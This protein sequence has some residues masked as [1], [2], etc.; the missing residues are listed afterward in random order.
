MQKWVM[1]WHYA[2]IDYNYEVGVFENIT[3]RAVIR[4]NLSGDK[5]KVCFQN[6]YSDAPMY[7]EHVK[8]RTRNRR[9]GMKSEEIEVTYKGNSQIVL[10]P[11]T[12]DFSDEIAHE[13]T[14]EDDFI[15]TMYFKEKTSIR[16]V[17]MTYAAYSWQSVQLTG[18]FTQTE[19]LGF[20]VKPQLV[21]GLAADP[22]PNQFVVGLS[23]VAVQ[24]SEDVKEIAL[25]GDSITHMSY[26]SDSLLELLYT[27]YPGK[28]SVVNAGICGN[29]L[30]K[31]YPP[32]KFM[33]GEG[34]QFGIAGKNR[35][36]R[37]LYEFSA[38]DLVFILEGVND[39]SHSIVFG[40]ET[41]PTADDIYAALKETVEKAKEKGSQVLVSTITPFGSFGA[42]WREQVEALRCAYNARIREGKLGDGWVDL[43]SVLADPGDVHR[44]Q[45]GMDLGDG[46]H[47]G[48]AGGKKMAQ[49]V[50]EKLTQDI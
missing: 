6:R 22:Y 48:W 35:I 47:P 16:S 23:G 11:D 21:P 39:C 14:W 2:P 44:M 17:C 12:E 18:D 1:A 36:M 7:I 10:A 27:A 43:D 30:Q 9:T 8:I 45:A 49:A 50:F 33:P 37:D 42:P 31:D 40:E 15:I 28:F 24:T 26:Y 13:I 46:V 20:T 25:F 19:E 5:L 34:H 3:Q 4:N 29:R 38:P 41:V 32:A